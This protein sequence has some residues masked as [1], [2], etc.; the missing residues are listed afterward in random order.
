MK[1]IVKESLITEDYSKLNKNMSYKPWYVQQGEEDDKEKEKMLNIAKEIKTSLLKVF[2][3]KKKILVSGGLS[4]YDDQENLVSKLNIDIN[5]Y[6][7]SHS[8]IEDIQVH[9]NYRN[10]L[11]NFS[12]RP[13][14]DDIFISTGPVVVHKI[15]KKN[16]ILKAVS[17]GI[18]YVDNIPENRL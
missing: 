18:H 9:F 3:N 13:Y 2:E 7:A 6:F 4:R 8:N 12:I 5:T 10:K 17:D 14:D 11:M 15:G 16:N 1:K